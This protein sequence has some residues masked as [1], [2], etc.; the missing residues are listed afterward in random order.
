MTD[1]FQEQIS[2]F[3]D[4]ELSPD[5][6]E[7]FVRRLQREP[8]SRDRLIRYHMIGAALRG[9]L[10]GRDTGILRRR[11][12]HALS[13]A[14]R[15]REV[16][17]I[18]RTR[19]WGAFAKSAAGIGIAAGVAIVAVLALQSV[20]LRGVPGAETAAAGAGLQATQQ[21]DASPSSYVVPLEAGERRPLSLPIGL[22]NYLIRHGEY[23]SNLGRTSV[24]SNVVA[25]GQ[26]GLT[27]EEEEPEQ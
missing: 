20:N 25:T 18:R 21:V 17:L 26:A 4:D 13:G 2:G 27:E 5:E 3:V 22:T 14:S 10:R 12:Q 19:R 11:L 16:P 24:H 6:C 23:A 7:F 8:E 9:E 1:P 15:L